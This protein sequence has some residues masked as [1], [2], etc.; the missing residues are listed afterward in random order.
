MSNR[1]NAVKITYRPIKNNE[2][3]PVA[4]IYKGM[5]SASGVLT[6]FTA[7]DASV[8][9]TWVTAF[10]VSIDA[11]GN[12]VPSKVIISTNKDITLSIKE[13]SKSSVKFGKTLSYWLKK[14]F[15]NQPGLIGSFPVVAANDKMRQGDTE[16]ML[17]ELNTIIEQIGANQTALTA[18]GWPAQNLAD[19]EGLHDSVETLNTQQELAKKLI[20][21]NTDAAIMTRNQCYSYI[22]TLITLKDI[23]Y[24][25]NLQKRYA[26]ALATNLNQIRSGGTPDTGTGGGSLVKEGSVAPGVTAGVDTEGINATDETR[27]I[28][29]ITLNG[30]RLSASETLDGVSGPV[31]WDVPIGNFDKSIEEFTALIGISD[32]RKYLKVQN[33]GPMTGHWKI[34]FTNLGPADAG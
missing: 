21:E 33:F 11:V 32:I 25:E 14:A 10:T 26:W 7:K 8:N 28:G 27:V 31:T 9:P 24:Y 19:Y 15:P 2:V 18:A 29:E 3:K 23:V 34:T 1:P 4:L 17:D 12:I 5:L 22:Q 6:L 30:L 13:N 20:P 16:G